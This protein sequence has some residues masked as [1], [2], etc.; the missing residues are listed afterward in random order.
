M[1]HLEGQGNV[2]VRSGNTC[3]P[4]VRFIAFD[5]ERLLAMYDCPLNSLGIPHSPHMEGV[6][7]QEYIVNPVTKIAA[8][9][10]VPQ[11]V[12]DKLKLD[13]DQ[14]VNQS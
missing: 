4:R 11:P 14:Y 13:I 3:H 10:A 9:S 1:P 12:T 6:V 7:L 2:S 5:T 8:H